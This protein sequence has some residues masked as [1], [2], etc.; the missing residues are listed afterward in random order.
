VRVDLIGVSG[1]RHV[2]ERSK[3][4]LGVFYDSSLREQVT[5]ANQFTP[6]PMHCRRVSK[7]VSQLSWGSLTRANL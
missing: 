1:S 2:Q 6:S 3:Q 5:L 4:G 7:G